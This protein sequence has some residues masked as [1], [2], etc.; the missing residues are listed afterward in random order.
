MHFFIYRGNHNQGSLTQP[1]AEKTNRLPPYM[2]IH[3]GKG[4]GGGAGFTFKFD[5]STVFL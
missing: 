4:G 1:S 3:K 2:F 5:K